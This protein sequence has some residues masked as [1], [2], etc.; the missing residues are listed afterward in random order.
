MQ[1]PS[2]SI[3]VSQ[4]NIEKHSFG[5]FRANIFF[6]CDYHEHLFTKGARILIL[7]FCFLRA[8][9]VSFC[10]WKLGEYYFCYDFHNLVRL[11][12]QHCIT[13]NNFRNLQISPKCLE[14]AAER[15]PFS[16]QTRALQLTSESSYAKTVSTERAVHQ[17]R[18]L[19]ED[20]K[21][22]ISLWLQWS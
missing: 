7:F 9:R 18:Y 20:R 14:E 3:T 22:N 2:K 19:G 8:G 10:L 13:V 6:V 1:F 16:L 4:Y 21:T 12:M 11:L 15:S 17:Q 5:D